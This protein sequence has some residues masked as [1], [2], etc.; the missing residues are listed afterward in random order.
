MASTAH[1]LTV[2]QKNYKFK[3]RS[4]R[5]K[6]HKVSYKNKRKRNLNKKKKRKRLISSRLV[7]MRR[8]CKQRLKHQIKKHIFSYARLKQLKRQIFLGTNLTSYA[9]I[10]ARNKNRFSNNP[11]HMLV[12][13]YH[14]AKKN[15]L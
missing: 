9:L 10:G 11:K 3:H 5:F 2:L 15:Q 13:K 12:R 4:L 14:A 8:F 6:T 1:R 7:A